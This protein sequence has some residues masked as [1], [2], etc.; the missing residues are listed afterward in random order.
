[1]KDVIAA[2]QTFVQEWSAVATIPEVDWRR[3]RGLEF[4]EVL[5]SRDSVAEQ[6]RKRQQL[7]PHFSEHVGR[8]ICTSLTPF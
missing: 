1:M 2:L 8:R 4:Q 3:L 6:S 5:R 7:C